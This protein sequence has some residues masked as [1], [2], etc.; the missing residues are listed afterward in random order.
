MENGKGGPIEPDHRP[1]DSFNG[2]LKHTKKTKTNPNNLLNIWPQGE[3][4]HNRGVHK[5]GA[6]VDDDR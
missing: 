4:V 2:L 5:D 1:E 3:Y 6:V